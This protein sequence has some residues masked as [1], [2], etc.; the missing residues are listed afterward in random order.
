MSLMTMSILH[1]ANESNVFD[2]LNTNEIL[3]LKQTY[4]N[5]SLEAI[6]SSQ[7]T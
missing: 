1:W 3:N 7:K 4:Y 5:I 2:G 6:W